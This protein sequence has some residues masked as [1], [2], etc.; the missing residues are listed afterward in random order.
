[1]RQNELPRNFQVGDRVRAL[2]DSGFG[3]FK[4][5]EVYTVTHAAGEGNIYGVILD[6]CSN[7]DSICDC[8]NLAKWKK[9][10]HWIP[11]IFELVVDPIT[12]E[13]EKRAVSISSF[14]INEAEE[15]FK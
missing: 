13:E 7:D 12:P 14:R 5:G 8:T 3:C 9:L 2:E 6:H 1:M 10:G 11:E 15:F 4:K